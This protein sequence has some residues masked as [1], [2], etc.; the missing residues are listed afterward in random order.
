MEGEK[1]SH[2]NSVQE[3]RL[4]KTRRVLNIHLQTRLKSANLGNDGGELQK[5]KK[6]GVSGDK[7]RFF[8]TKQELFGLEMKERGRFETCTLS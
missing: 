3:V 5:K 2:W 4:Q 6:N 1:N 7:I 8:C